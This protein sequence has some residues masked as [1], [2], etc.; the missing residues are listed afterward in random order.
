MNGEVLP[1]PARIVVA[2]PVRH[3]VR[4][5][6]VAG[7]LAAVSV[8]LPAGS[9]ADPVVDNPTEAIA[10]L[11]EI[12]RESEQ[13][14]EALHNAQIDLDAKLDAQREQEAR[15]E[16]DRGILDAATAEVAR[17]QPTVDKL[18]TAN[19]QGARTNR[20][21]ALLVSD[22]PQQLLDQMSALDVIAGRTADDVSQYTAAS[23]QA[24]E[25]AEASQASA[26]AARAASEQAKALSDDLQRRQSELEAQIVEVTKAFEGLTGAE[27][28][29]LAGTPF[30]PGVDP[31]VILSG[32]VPGAGSGAL[33][34]GL[35]RIGSPYAWGATGPSSFDCS[36]LVVWSYKQI[37]KNLPRSSQAQ[38]Q[39]GIPVPRD[40]LQ[41]GDVVIFYN[42]ASHVG[43]YAGGGNVL[44]ASTF[45]VPVKVESMDR[46]PYAGARRY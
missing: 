19:Y 36:G 24:R 35:T 22:S 18:V 13:T 14:N 28:A 9:G 20:L 34:A 46:M 12:A 10:R 29:Q 3:S 33:Q 25:A 43:I 44:H 32:L 37:G 2:R 26:D 15:A 42:D 40:Q 21:F 27:R 11:G 38:A 4:A 41:P 45:G 30:P 1:V 6:L 5:A 23:A 7:V 31:G 8:V 17:F 39:G 16:H